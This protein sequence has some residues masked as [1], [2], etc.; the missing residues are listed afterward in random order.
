MRL[1]QQP[2]RDPLPTT[3]EIEVMNGLKSITVTLVALVVGLVF[4]SDAGAQGEAQWEKTV[5]AA[6]KEGELSIYLNA[7][8]QV[9]PALTKA[10]DERFGIKIY[11]VTGTGPELSAKIVSEYS[12][13]LHQAD[14]SFQGCSTLIAL[15]G[16]HG[17]LAPIE[18][19][20]ILPEVRDG[21][22]WF[23]G[24][25][26]YDKAGTAFRFINHALP[27]VV[28]NTD[29][30]KANSIQSFLDLQRPEWKKKILMHD[31]S[32]LGAGANGISYLATLWG[33]SK[34]KD[35]LSTLLK[36]QEAG[37]TRN[38][39]QHVEWVGQ[40]KYAVGLWPNPG[41]VARYVKAGAPIAVTHVKEGAVASP[42]FGCLG[43][44]A[45]PAHPNAATVF[46]NWFLSREGQTLAVKA[47]E[48]PSARLD[49]T[50]SGVLKEFVIVPEQKVFVENEEFN[51]MQDKWI[52]EWKAVVESVQ[53]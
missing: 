19:M 31:P 5:A 6:K 43:V 33:L 39:Q 48:L 47:Y 11:V 45:K 4:L 10:F 7:P 9:R 32:I 22:A 3:K 35:Y 2:A 46:V 15:I 42:A 23:G 53:R 29:S 28:Y 14:V 20:L 37:V 16:T 26:N 34:A 30:V 52:P 49:V 25:L 21:K 27:P 8:A 44:P 17:Y 24:K 38:Y 40:G 50:A 41:Q 51:A 18:P 1:F 12:A 13:G 36:A